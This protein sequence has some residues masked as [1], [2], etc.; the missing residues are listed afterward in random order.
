MQKLIEPIQ[1]EHLM[2]MRKQRVSPAFQTRPEK[3]DVQVRSKKG[4]KI[5]QSELT[6]MSD[7]NV[8]QSIRLRATPNSS[9][10]L[11]TSVLFPD[12]NWR[13]KLRMMVDVRDEITPEP[14]A[15]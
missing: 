13:Q 9:A 15:P 14:G 11:A 3:T 12:V 10:T 6:G 5:L 4:A 1:S 2:N 8:K 7:A